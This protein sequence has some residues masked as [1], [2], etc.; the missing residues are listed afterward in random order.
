MS[1]WGIW[2][3]ERAKASLRLRLVTL[4]EGFR[5]PRESLL[6]V[7]LGLYYSPRLHGSLDT[8]VLAKKVDKERDVLEW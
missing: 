4:E 1:N 7:L 8:K 6:D 2:V 5:N 3:V